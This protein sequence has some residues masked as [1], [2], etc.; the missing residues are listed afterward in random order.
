MQ[1]WVCKVDYEFLRVIVLLQL[2]FILVITV[3]MVVMGFNG[4]WGFL[5]VIMGLK[6]DCWLLVQIKSLYLRL[7][8][9]NGDYRFLVAIMGLW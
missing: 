5:M 4:N 3:L 1:L 9:F 7:W 6:G 8:V 2:C